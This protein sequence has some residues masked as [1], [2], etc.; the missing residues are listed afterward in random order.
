MSARVASY[1][2]SFA[3]L[4]S[5]ALSI[6][7]SDFVPGREPSRSFTPHALHSLLM[8]DGQSSYT[9]LESPEPI[10]AMQSRPFTA[11]RI[12]AASCAEFNVS[13]VGATTVST[14]VETARLR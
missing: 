7:W 9:G 13:V 11:L 4:H 3:N 10:H 2:P 5:S 8:A 14:R 1:S 12:S 6:N